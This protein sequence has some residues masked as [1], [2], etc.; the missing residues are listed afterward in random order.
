MEAISVSKEDNDLL[1]K[2]QNFIRKSLT[3]RKITK[4]SIIKA[5]LLVE[6]TV[7]LL[8]QHAPEKAVLSVKIAKFLG[9]VSIELKIEGQEFS[10]NVIT[11]SNAI[12][13]E[14]EDA[15]R[16]IVLNAF[17]ERFKYSNKKGINRVRILVEKAERS[18]LFLTV[19]ALCLGLL[20]GLLI[21]NVLPHMAGDALCNYVLRPAKDM[22]MRAI[23]IVIAPVVFFSLATCISQFKNLADLGRM[24]AKVMG[25]YLFTTIV[26]TS[27]GIGMAF[28]FHPGEFGFALESNIE[29]TSAVVAADVNISLV[30]TIRNIVP[31][32]LFKPFVESDT[33][34]IMFLSIL[35]G[36]AVGM[37]GEYSA[38]LKEL[39]EACNSLFLTITT[40]IAKVIPVAVFCSVALMIV[41][42]GGASLKMVLSAAAVQISTIILMICFYGLLVLIVARINPVQFFKKIKEGMVT[43]FTLC[44][45]S[46]A[47]PTNMKICKEQLGIAPKLCNFSIPLGATVNMDGTCIFLTSFSLFLARAYG[48]TIDSSSIFSIVVVIVLLSLAAP[49]VP[50][51]GLICLGVVLMEIGVPVEAIGLIIAINPI[52]D[53]FDTMNNTTGDMAATLIVAKSEGMIDM[54]VFNQ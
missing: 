2:V 42:M 43:S 28:L 26:A 19:M 36:V 52:I 54:D 22:F 46:A 41:D 34:Q 39:F 47:M 37:I 27:L 48:V 24:A 17:G 30:D 20:F 3:A 23:R 11:D 50:G 21:E 18:N 14:S 12:D 49:G 51:N 38:V 1:E 4:S 35:V 7:A 10:P 13:N 44:S 53:M 16:S 5:E 45:S 6:E 9:D 40:M 25:I 29:N 15:I 33:L 32:N 8:L 31:D